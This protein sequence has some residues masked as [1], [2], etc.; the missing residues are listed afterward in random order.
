M[1]NRKLF[2]EASF[3]LS[4]T[5]FGGLVTGTIWAGL[6]QTLASLAGL[7]AIVPVIG[8][9]RG[10]I[11]GIFTSRIGTGLHLGSIQPTL[12]KRS[13]EFNNT[14]LMNLSLSFI[15][16]IWVGFIVYLLHFIA[17][18]KT[19]FLHF[20]F[21]SIIAGIVSAFIQ[22][23]LALFIAFQI[24]KRGMDPDVLAYPLLSMIADVTTAVAILIG[25]T[26]DRSITEQLP[27]VVRF[28]LELV[29][30]FSLISFL[31]IIFSRPI[32]SKLE[33]ELFNLLGESVPVVWSAVIIGGFVGIIMD[34]SIPYNGV[35]LV[36]PI[37]MAYTGSMGAII[38]SKF[39][40]AY[41]LGSLSSREGKLD[42]YL[43]TPL[44]LLL[45]GLLLSTGLGLVGYFLSQVLGYGLPK[46]DL[47]SFVIIC[48]ATGLVTTVFSI[49]NALVVGNIT[50]QRGIDADNI[51][52][53]LT[54]TIGD[55]VAVVTIVIAINVLLLF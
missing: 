34:G 11:S 48:W 19:T 17:G 45:I 30:I 22:I 52:V 25:F 12:R 39:T 9:M 28:F 53:P 26:V 2:K 10:N 33:F 29:G 49:F 20:L 31:L 13:K 37:Y 27:W 8:Q 35:I 7:I 14:V 1:S 42:T 44:I 5:V 32:R 24:F 15:T 46:P 41:Y 43:F 21:V 23:F 50:F 3:A 36:L 54:S 40:T 6:D 51:I 47:L 38:G 4:L 55:L 18:G 16:P